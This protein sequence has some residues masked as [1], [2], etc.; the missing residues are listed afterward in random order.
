MQAVAEHPY[1]EWQFGVQGG[2]ETTEG[3]AQ[4]VLLV[5]RCFVNEGASVRS[6]KSG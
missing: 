5:Q 6:V 1:P 2:L 3:T 4:M